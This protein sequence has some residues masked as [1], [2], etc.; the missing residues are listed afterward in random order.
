[1][2]PLVSLVALVLHSR[3]T[4]W[5]SGARRGPVRVIGDTLVLRQQRI[6][7]ERLPSAAS[8]SRLKTRRRL[9]IQLHALQKCATSLEPSA[10]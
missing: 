1:M 9:F 10:W 5:V 6:E 7:L 2:V 3:L 8:T 4:F